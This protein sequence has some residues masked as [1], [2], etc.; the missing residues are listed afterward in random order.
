MAANRL[1][2]RMSAGLDINGPLEELRTA[3]MAYDTAVVTLRGGK[4]P[5]GDGDN[6]MSVSQLFASDAQKHLDAID[7]QWGGYKALLKPVLDFSGSPYAA[8]APA[9]APGA[10][11]AYS[12]RGEK[13]KVA[14]EKLNAYGEANYKGLAQSTNELATLLQTEN[15]S[16]AS[17]LKWIQRGGMLLTL[18]LFGASCSTS[19]PT[20]ARKSASPSWRARKRRTS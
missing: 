12:P 15:V 13:L 6:K 7:K 2:E 16:R 14:L 1:A 5:T 20:C 3:A 9:A 11:I 4:L 17:T 18:G 8:A 19:S 10:T